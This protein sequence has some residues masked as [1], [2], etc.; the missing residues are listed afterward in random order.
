MIA[1]EAMVSVI[2]WKKTF[3]YSRA[4]MASGEKESL[5]EILL[6]NGELYECSPIISRC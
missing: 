5:P 1:S 6:R 2:T 4:A 3:K